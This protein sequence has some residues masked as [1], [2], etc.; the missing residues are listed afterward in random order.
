MSCPPASAPSMTTGLR[1]A[2]AAYRAAVSP[3]GPDPTMT[4]S[5]TSF[6]G[7]F[8]GSFG[9]GHLCPPRPA[10]H[11]GDDEDS[12]EDEVRRPDTPGQVDVDQPE[13]PDRHDGQGGSDEERREQPEDDRPGHVL[14]GCD[15]LVAN[16]RD[17]PL[18]VVDRVGRP[19][20]HGTPSRP[21]TRRAYL[22][23]SRLPRLRA[24]R[25]PRPP[26]TSPCR[27]A[28]GWRSLVAAAALVSGPRP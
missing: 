25:R 6:M 24:G 23:P 19:V 16:G 15:R 28:R 14:G 22:A 9:R 17:D 27:A 11:A 21:R 1:S 3:A 8:P 4:S 12:A 10:E 7:R 26:G 20:A 5:R 18:D 13:Q 2:R